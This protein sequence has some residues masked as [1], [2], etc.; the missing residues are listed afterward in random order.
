MDPRDLKLRGIIKL[1]EPGYYALR[2]RI[3][4]GEASVRDLEVIGAVA[5]KYGRGY[6]SLTSRLGVEIP[7]VREEDLEAARAELARAGIVLAG[8]GPRVRSIVVCKGN[9]C[10]YGLYDI[11]ALGEE[12][13]RRFNGPR[14]LPHKFKIALS[15]CSNACSR[16]QHNDFG[17]LGR[18]EPELIDDLCTGCELCAVR[19]PT[20]AITMRGDLPRRDETKCILC[21]EC[22]EAC[23][24]GAW[25]RARVGVSIYLGGKYGKM[26]RRGHLLVE[27]YPVEEVPELVGRVLDFY[28]QHGRAGERLLETVE[29]VGLEETAR[30]LGVMR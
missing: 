9:V 8:C 19:C 3:P 15:G 27:L 2:L 26:P 30:A 20:G 4:M 21:G 14:I 12:L 16:P 23:P 25:R 1:R 22:V 29:R 18:V 5:S 6:V 10:P 13:D 24:T 11:K 28:A 7:W 17:A